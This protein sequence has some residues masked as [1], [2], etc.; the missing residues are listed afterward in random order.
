MSDM[1]F[2]DDDDDDDEVESLVDLR[3]LVRDD[4]GSD[5]SGNERP[6]K[7]AKA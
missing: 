2:E 1:D 7:K 6:K 5:E 3:E 4:V